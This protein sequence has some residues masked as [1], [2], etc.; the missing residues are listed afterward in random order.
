MVDVLAGHLPGLGSELEGIRANG[1][2]AV[3][4]DMAIHDLYGGHR[5]DGN[6][7]G[8]WMLASSAVSYAV[9]LDVGEL[10][11][12]A[13]EARTQQ[14]IGDAFR[15]GAEAGCG[16]VII[17]ELEAGGGGAILITATIRRAAKNDDGIEGG[18]AGGSAV[19]GAEAGL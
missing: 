6:L 18:S 9:D 17:V 5:L 2:T 11:E 8:R 12:E 19:V 1:A 14:E 13:V 16:T 10:L 3:F 15:Q 7:R 4:L